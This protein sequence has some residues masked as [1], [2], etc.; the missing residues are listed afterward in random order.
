MKQIKKTHAFSLLLAIC[1]NTSYA[2]FTADGNVSLRSHWIDRDQENQS[3]PY[4]GVDKD[5][6]FTGHLNTLWEYTPYQVLSSQL[7]VAVRR[8]DLG[9]PRKGTRVSRANIKYTD[10]V[11]ALP[12]V[13]ETGDFFAQHSSRSL[14]RNLKGAQIEFQPQTETRQSIQILAGLDSN[15]WDTAGDASRYLALSWLAEAEHFGAFTLGHVFSEDSDHASEQRTTAFAWNNSTSFA[16]N[17]HHIEWEAEWLHHGN[18]K[19]AGN[20]AFAS[21]ASR[22]WQGK[23]RLQL[24]YELYDNDFNPRGGVTGGGQRR[25]DASLY[26]RTA[27]G[28]FNASY[29]Q[30]NFFA[31]RSEDTSTQ[32]GYSHRFFQRVNLN[33]NMG[34]RENSSPFGDNKNRSLNADVSWSINDYHALQLSSSQS[35]DTYTSNFSGGDSRNK[36]KRQD[37]TIGFRSVGN[38]WNGQW[39]LAPK[40]SWRESTS[41]TSRSEEVSPGI[42]LGFR[43]SRHDLQLNYD[44]SQSEIDN[45][46]FADA[47]T[48]NY[49]L[50]ARYSYQ[51]ERTRWSIELGQFVSNGNFVDELTEDTLL[52]SVDHRFQYRDST[53]TNP[54]AALQH[55]FSPVDPLLALTH[56]VGSGEFA[57]AQAVILSANPASQINAANRSVYT[58]QFLPGEFE[59]QTLEIERRHGQLAEVRWSIDLQGKSPQEVERIFERTRTQLYANLG[60]P[61]RREEFGSIASLANGELNKAVNSTSLLRLNEWRINGN[62]LRFGIPRSLDGEAKLRIY[63]Q[64]NF[65]NGLEDSWG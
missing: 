36:T 5:H 65:S 42:S 61:T 30:L 31:G 32:I 47:R 25:W 45:D 54:Q 19:N 49:R 34:K 27:F 9:D 13:I 64:P 37:I 62:T 43:H 22:L 14:R 41:D 18:E 33:V 29:N 17:Q 59:Q 35:E 39:S 23:T 12:Y 60:E 11:A 21:I 50:N 8:T 38:L 7:G 28:N 1:A 3:S 53:T 46:G 57:V 24:A 40:L 48:K 6:E 2:G 52:L 55:E 44:N 10:G 58:G 26:Q 63:F 15:E 16:E 51:Q 20:G 4:S 56:L